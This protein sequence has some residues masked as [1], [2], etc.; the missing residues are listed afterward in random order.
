MDGLGGETRGTR[1]RDPGGD[2]AAVVVR[3]FFVR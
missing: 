2:L 1:R 3:V